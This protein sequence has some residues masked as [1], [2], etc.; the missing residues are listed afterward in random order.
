[1][2]KEILAVNLLRLTSRPGRNRKGGKARHRATS[3]RTG[4]NSKNPENS[5]SKDNKD[6]RSKSL[7]K[8]I[9]PLR[10]QINKQKAWQVPGFLL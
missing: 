1:M 6:L 9:Q 4:R 10:K 5:N 3:N 7:L 8:K 2:S